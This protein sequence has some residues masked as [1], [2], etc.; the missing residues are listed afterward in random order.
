MTA[1]EKAQS[2][3]ELTDGFRARLAAGLR[4]F[5]K[6]AAEA[7]RDVV[8]AGPYVE[9]EPN[10]IAADSAPYEDDAPTGSTFDAGSTSER[11]HAR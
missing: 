3:T 8:I 10:E 2:A 6:L 4:E 9:D 1:E 5:T 7:L 11:G